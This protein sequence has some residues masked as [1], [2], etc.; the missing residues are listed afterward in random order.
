MSGHVS[1][2]TMQMN[3]TNNDARA[4]SS[5]ASTANVCSL[6]SKGTL[7]GARRTIVVVWWWCVYELEIAWEVALV[8]GESERDVS[9]AAAMNE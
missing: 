4:S 3:S 9:E 1:G 2:D 7:K 5:I 8:L 6:R